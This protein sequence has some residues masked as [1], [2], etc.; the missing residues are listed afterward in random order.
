MV[1]I[2]SLIGAETATAALLF[3]HWELIMLILFRH[4]E[5]VAM[6]LLIS[7][8]DC[9]NHQSWQEMLMQLAEIKPNPMMLVDC[10]DVVTEDVIVETETGTI[11]P[12][13]NCFVEQSPRRSNYVT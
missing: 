8:K 13:I 5:M 12:T 7:L 9:N 4:W 10:S 2:F 6:N 1:V 3:R 11:I